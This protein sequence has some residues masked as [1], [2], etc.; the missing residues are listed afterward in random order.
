MSLPQLVTSTSMLHVSASTRLWNSIF[1]W[2]YSP[3]LTSFGGWN[4]NYI[5]CGI[6]IITERFS[7]SHCAASLTYLVS[8][9]DKIGSF[10][11]LATFCTTVVPGGAK[12]TQT[13]QP[14]EPIISIFGYI[15]TCYSL[16][17][18]RISYWHNFVIIPYIVPLFFP[19][20]PLRESSTIVWHFPLFTAPKLSHFWTPPLFPRIFILISQTPQ[21][22]L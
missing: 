17:L 16:N 5:L 13:Y 4:L 10:Q 1:V 9:F 14:P 12:S 7:V 21:S 15:P 3:R 18:H 19:Q 8:G 6:L 11:V 2:N 20:W 22:L